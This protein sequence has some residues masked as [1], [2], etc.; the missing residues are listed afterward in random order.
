MKI[1][2]KDPEE[3]P[4]ELDIAL[5]LEYTGGCH[6]A[7]QVDLLFS[8]SV[9]LAVKLVYLK[10]RARLQLSRNPCSHWSF[11]FYEVMLGIRGGGGI[12]CKLLLIGPEFMQ[13]CIK[14]V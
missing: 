7:I 1:G 5:D 2:T 9:H 10:G 4:Q 13:L 3:V 14:G 11:A 6:L 8:R 12:Y